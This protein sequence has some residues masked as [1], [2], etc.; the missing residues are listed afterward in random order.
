MNSS[1]RASKLSSSS[2]AELAAIKGKMVPY[3]R[4]W[5]AERERLALVQEKSKWL[6][7][8]DKL[9]D[10]A[11]HY[12]SRAIHSEYL[13][14]TNTVYHGRNKVTQASF[15]G[16]DHCNAIKIRD[17]MKELWEVRKFINPKKL[18]YAPDDPDSFY[19]EMTEG[20]DLPDHIPRKQYWTEKVIPIANKYM[21]DTRSNT[22]S[23]TKN[24]YFGEMFIE[25][26][27][28][29]VWILVLSVHLQYSPLIFL[30]LHER[31]WERICH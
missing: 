2:K 24:S 26:V 8:Q 31:A 15:Q 4:W 27:L 23:A 13:V 7:E 19:N 1:N 22:N 14:K 11:K 10:L 3:E 5:K 6:D 9:A 18:V 28:W 17:K 16:Y 29:M 25:F 30:R 20:L 12:K 21:G